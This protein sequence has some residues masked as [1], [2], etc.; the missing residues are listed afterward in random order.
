M[1]AYATRAPLSLINNPHMMSE[2]RGG[3]RRSSARLADKEDAPLT[4]GVGH[5]YEPV[6]GLQNNGM[7]GKQGKAKI[8]GA[9]TK[10][11]AK[12]KP[13]EQPPKPART[14]LL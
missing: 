2:A 8:N 5:D 7:V 3:G 14:R 10:P 6:K 13:G 1:T 12:R 9:S 4:N 11:A